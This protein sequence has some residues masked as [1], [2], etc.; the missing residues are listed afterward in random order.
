M[1][2]SFSARVVQRAQQP[3]SERA[4]VRAVSVGDQVERDHGREDEQQDNHRDALQGTVTGYSVI[5][6]YARILD[7]VG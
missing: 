2:L 7:S 4:A 5:S 3:P 1:V 6:G